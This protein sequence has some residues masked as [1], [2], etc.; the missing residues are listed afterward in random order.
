MAQRQWQQGLSW[1][2]AFALLVASLRGLSWPLLGRLAKV[3]KTLA[4]NIGRNRT[5]DL[6][7]GFLGQL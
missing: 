3:S 6:S 5:D 2:L 4:H 7:D 1:P